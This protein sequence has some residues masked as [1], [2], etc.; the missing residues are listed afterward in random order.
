MPVITLADGSQRS[1]PAP[2]SVLAVAESIS[3]SLTKRCVAGRINGLLLD[4]SDLVEQDATVK[5]IT[6]DSSE[7]LGIIRH[8]CAHLLGHALKQLWPEAQMAIGPVIKDGFY[9]DV[10]LPQ[11]LDEAAL[12]QLENRMRELAR[13]N[14][15][16]VKRRVSWQQAYEAF[17]QRNESYKVAILE[18]NISRSE[19]PALY[20]HQEYLD[21]CRG[22]HVPTI[23]FCQHFK[24]LKV[25]G[26]YWRG[27]SNNRMLQRIYGTVWTDAEALQQY[28]HRLSEAAKRDHRKIG[29]QL[30]LYHM[31]EAAPG[32]VFWHPNGWTLF[33][34]LEAFIREQLA[35]YHYQEVKGPM[36]LDRQL[37]QQSGH[38]EKYAEHM[39]T[40]A[41]ENREYA[42]KP[43]NCPGHVQIFNQGLKTYRDLPLRLAEFGCCH[44][45]EPS[46]A[47][48]GLMRVR[49]FTQDDAHIFCTEAQIQA[50][51]SGCIAMVYDTYA[52]FGFQRVKVKLSTR[53]EKRIGTDATW[54]R[55]EQALMEALQSHQLAFELQPGEGAFYGPKIEF[56]LYDC[57]DRS[58]QCGTIQL[59]FALPGRLG[60]TYVGEDNERHVP[61]MIHRAILGSLER[62]IGILIEE[63]AGHFPTWLAPNQ[64]VIMNITD[65]QEHY[66]RH[67]QQQLQNAAIRAILDLRNQKI[68]FKIREHTL[69]RIPYLLICGD[70]EIDNQ[71]VAVRTR[72]GKDLGTMPVEQFIK[73]LQQQ[74]SSRNLHLL[75]E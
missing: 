2:V 22:P 54:D 21:M 44:R 26:A 65:K 4:A 62:F 35:A 7:G 20:Q 56:T 57:L 71:C 11:P 58:W 16:V 36:M 67:I 66:V 64:V 39:F 40:T 3:R 51:V 18:E 49:A 6:A 5:I 15:P 25:S 43:M 74:I 61:V 10:D 13:S 52:T 19:Q 42:I 29:Q 50:E 8:S 27:N 69:S 28:L 70:Q 75:E 34:R 17:A 33:Q 72:R 14:Y 46:G 68:G 73:L 38:W 24:L 47:L 55:A 63:Y 32:M 41:S 37:W 59:D 45:N 30:Q 31:Q 60:A 1:Y 48:H 23:G 53:P 12:A 9:Y